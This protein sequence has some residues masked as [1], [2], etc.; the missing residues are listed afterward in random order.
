[1]CIL[2]ILCGRSFR[3]KMTST[4]LYATVARSSIVLARYAACPGNFQEITDHILT[5]IGTQDERMTYTQTGL[6]NFTI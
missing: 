6:H 1:M 3:I 2:C 4:I 5:K